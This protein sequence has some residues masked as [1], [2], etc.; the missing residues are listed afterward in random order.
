MIENDN[1]LKENSNELKVNNNE[2]K[3]QKTSE[4]NKEGT[5]EN[6]EIIENEH[7]G[8]KFYIRLRFFV[9]VMM[10]LSVYFF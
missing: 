1:E 3:D 10:F 6:N 8:K 5:K 2:L 7:T 4:A 9:Y